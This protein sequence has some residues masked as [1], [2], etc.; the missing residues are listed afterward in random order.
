MLSFRAAPAVAIAAL[1]LALGQ[2]PAVA[3]SFDGYYAGRLMCDPIPGKAIGALNIAF[4]LTLTRGNATYRRAIYAPD[5]KMFLTNETGEGRVS[6]D[7]LVTLNGRAEFSTWHYDA[8]YGGKII[9][10]AL[11]LT[12][13]QHWEFADAPPYDRPCKASVTR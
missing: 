10:N 12:G 3:Q 11:E 9:G 2:T 1:A 5:G 7:G 8:S 4:S 6:A 13:K